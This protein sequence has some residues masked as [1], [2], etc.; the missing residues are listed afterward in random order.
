[1]AKKKIYIDPSKRGTFT[2]EAKKRGMGVQEFASKVMSNKDRYSSSMVKQANFA[3]NAANW[4]QDGGNMNAVSLMG[5][6]DDSPFRNEESLNIYSPDGLI[7]MSNVGMPIVA[8]G[9]VLDPYSGI[10]QVPPTKSGY[11]RETPLI[12]KHGGSI[13]PAFN[14]Y[15]KGGKKDKASKLTRQQKKLRLRLDSYMKDFGIQN[16]YIRAGI[17]GGIEAEGGPEGIPEGSYKNT[18]VDRIRKIFGARVADLN[19]KEITKLRKNDKKF[20][21]H[22]YG[23]AA[24]SYYTD[25]KKGAWDPGNHNKEDG[26]KYRGRGLNQLTFKAQYQKMQNQLKK[27]G[28]DYDLVNHP[29][30]L[31]KDKN[32]QALVA[33]KSYAERLNKMPRGQFGYGKY[34]D[35]DNQEDAS[36]AVAYGNAGW[37][38]AP[39]NEY[40][41]DVIRRSPK[42]FEMP[43]DYGLSIDV[44]Q[45]PEVIVRPSILNN[46]EFQNGGGLYTY[47][48]RPGAVYE[49]G[50]DGNWKLNLGA[51]TQGKFIPIVDPRLT[52]TEQLNLNA[53]PLEETESVVPGYNESAYF[54][55]LKYLENSIKKGF[56]DGRWYPH[57]SLEGGEKTIAY[58]HKLKKGEDF[59]KGLSQEE[60]EALMLKDYTVKKSS[61]QKHV[62]KEFGKGTFENLDPRKQILLTDYQ[63][64]VGLTKFPKLTEAVVTDN[65]DAALKEYKRYH[66]GKKPLV[67]RNKWTEEQ[68]KSFAYGGNIYK[69]GGY[70]VTRSND[71]KGKTHK[72]TRKSDG[73]VKY[74]GHPMK[75]QPKNKKVKKAAEA[76][77]RAQGNFRNPFFKAYWD[78]TWK[79]GG[80]MDSYNSYQFG[81]SMQELQEKESKS[82]YDVEGVNKEKLQEW[83]NIGKVAPTNIGEAKL[84]AEAV[85]YTPAQ[86]NIVAAQWALESARGTKTGGQF[87]YFGIKSH[88][89]ATRDKLKNKYNINVSTAAPVSTQEEFTPGKKETIKSSFLNFDD[90][91]A[92]FLGHKAFLETNKRYEKALKAETSFD[93]AKE[94]KNAG[95]ATSAKYAP[96]LGSIAYPFLSSEEIEKFKSLGS[97][98]EDTLPKNKKTKLVQDNIAPTPVVKDVFT[99]TEI[100]GTKVSDAKLFERNMK[101]PKN[102]TNLEIKNVVP[103]RTPQFG[104]S[105]FGQ[106]QMFK[107]YGGKTYQGN[108]YRNGEILAGISA[109]LYGAAEGILDTVT[110]GLTNNLTNKGFDALFTGEKNKNVGGIRGAGNVVGGVAG[111][112]IN[113]AGTGTAVGQVAGGMG[114]MAE[115]TGN[116]RLDAAGN[117]IE[118]TGNVVGNFVAYGGNIHQVDPNMS[119]GTN[120][121]GKQY[122]I[123]AGYKEMYQ[124]NLGEAIPEGAT[125]S[126]SAFDLFNTQGKISSWNAPNTPDP[127]AEKAY[128]YADYST[129]S[130]DVRANPQSRAKQNDYVKPGQ[131]KMVHPDG[132]SMYTDP[133]NVQL[134]IQKGYQ[135]EGVNLVDAA[136]FG[137]G[138]KYY[139]YGS[140]MY[141]DYAKGGKLPES[142]LRS[143]LE[144]HMS[145]SEANDYINSYKKGGNMIKRADGSYSQRGLWD[146]IRANKGSGKKP[147][148]EML[149]QEKKIKGNKNTYGS[150]MYNN[151]GFGMNTMNEI[152]VTEFNAGGTHEQNPLGGIPQGMGTNGKVN[153]VEQGE[154]KIT[155]PRDPSGQ[156]KFIVSAQKDMIITKEIAEENNLPKTFVNKTVRKAADMLLRKD[157]RREGDTIE[158]NSKQQDLIGFLQAHETLT[159]MKEAEQNAEFQEKM[160]TLSEEYP[161]Q[162]AT[163]MPPQ[164]EM[165]TE[166]APEM[167]NQIPLG[168]AMRY[169]GK[170]KKYKYGHGSNMYTM[171]TNVH[172]VDPN[173]TSFTPTFPEPTPFSAGVADTL[174]LRPFAEMDTAGTPDISDVDV[175]VEILKKDLDNYEKE[176]ARYKEMQDAN[177]QDSEKQSFVNYAG[178]LLPAALNI[179]MGLF[180]EEDTVNLGRVSSRTLPETDV[181]QQL[182]DARMSAARTANQMRGSGQAGSYLA[183]IANLK[184]IDDATKARIYQDKYNKDAAIAARQAQMDINV[185][186]ANLGLKAQEEQYKRAAEAAKQRQLFTG[187]GQVAQKLR[188]D[189]LDDIAQAYNRQFSDRYGFDYE[190]PFQR[191]NKRK[192]KK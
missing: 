21:D 177:S 148:K 153:L 82:Y 72:V 61:A 41:N 115:A 171:G 9:Q 16:P 49:K 3:R 26:W 42:Y 65:I 29:E 186:R 182:R 176:L 116:E 166:M 93:F 91:I 107:T 169:G 53:V 86:S 121:L 167:P 175:E 113:P 99:P 37:G 67:E 191:K 128:K 1:M 5:Y 119:V 52:R 189:Q 173:M 17:L 143:R 47:P 43:K 101:L 181:S 138:G 30:L 142:V 179:G 180:G 24:M 50:T 48:G 110:L 149:K 158:E 120:M 164:S 106:G 63:Y 129:G 118:A 66:S 85:G 57:V 105:A 35:I 70:T 89:K 18:S 170:K 123:P 154:L 184:N 55:D 126:Q 2:A 13:S 60:A 84:L 139:G 146:N 150:N 134:L 98:I 34:S 159:A 71:R 152:P 27:L 14:M 69:S 19:D 112:F 83:Y 125:L 44:Q 12:A 192:N 45:I 7:D 140:K 178:Q 94:L 104:A 64:N 25:R 141:N 117:V 28:Y 111:G 51:D 187:I 77:H 133:Q 78:K 127:S 114:E 75:N 62:D 80:V 162:M 32:L 183:N 59:S 188:A 163:I 76:R 95:Y 185:D 87:N 160:M 73:K 36:R 137:Y 81:G 144:S 46:T 4:N 11:V 58:G 161:E 145:K 108:V 136:T 102:T 103:K 20:F 10:N 109:G 6:R 88:S 190:K 100:P 165:E 172:Q 8:N 56:K 155:D 135:Q 156:S 147:T 22:V 33:V 31:D 151:G 130:G 79:N 74:Y 15:D 40:T 96:T 132:R 54:D 168:M 38:E 122:A 157:S 90:P 39:R 174:P 68:I 131:V 92:A 23:P 97:K 124:Q